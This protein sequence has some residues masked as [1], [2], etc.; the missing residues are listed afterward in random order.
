MFVCGTVNGFYSNLH[1]IPE[2]ERTSVTIFSVICDETS[3]PSCTAVTYRNDEWVSLNKSEEG[4]LNYVLNSKNRIDVSKLL[5]YNRCLF[6]SK[7]LLLEYMIRNGILEI[8]EVIPASD[9]QKYPV[10]PSDNSCL[11]QEEKSR[12]DKELD[13]YHALH[14]CE[15]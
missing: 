13:D 15:N 8:V 4:V 12:L 7:K 2:S 11:Y 9:Y 5:Y 6:I 10:P 3:V 1:D 14:K